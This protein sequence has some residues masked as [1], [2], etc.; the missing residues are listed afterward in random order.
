M[1]CL[2]VHMALTEEDVAALRWVEDEQQRLTFFQEE[3]EEFYFTDPKTYVAESDKAW[4]AIHRT[5]T[6]GTLTCDEGAYPLSHVVLGGESLYSQPDYIM[7]L[8]NPQHARDIA[9]ALRGISEVEFR[10]GYNAIDPTD[11]GHDLTDEDFDY[12]WP[13]FQNVRDLYRHAAS[14]GRYVLFTADQ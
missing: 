4:D 5:L 6:N 13:W 1:S 11:Y 10:K 2:G 3:I 14:E 9:A 7:S 8:K 12:T